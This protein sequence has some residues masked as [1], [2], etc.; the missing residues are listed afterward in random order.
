MRWP[1]PAA[2]Q[3]A[4]LHRLRQPHIEAEALAQ[5]LRLRVVAAGAPQKRPLLAA[6]RAFTPRGGG[7]VTPLSNQLAQCV[8]WLSECRDFGWVLPWSR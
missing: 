7:G 5:Q 2:E 8:G 6:F 3:S 1:T 4:R